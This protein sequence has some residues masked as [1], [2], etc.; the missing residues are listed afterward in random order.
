M[1]KRTFE[2]LVFDALMDHFYMDLHISA[3]LVSLATLR[4]RKGGYVYLSLDALMH[5]P[6][7]CFQTFESS[8]ITPTNLTGDDN[9]TVVNLHMRLVFESLDKL[10]TT[11]LTSMSVLGL[12]LMYNSDVSLEELFVS[13]LLPTVTA[14]E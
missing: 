12:A 4:A 1:T 5:T 14:L 13:V 9:T 8:I 3:F 7:V 11:D 2:C 6:L 10:F